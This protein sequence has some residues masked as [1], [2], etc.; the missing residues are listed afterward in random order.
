MKSNIQISRGSPRACLMYLDDSLSLEFPQPS[1]MSVYAKNGLFA[2]ETIDMAPPSNS[3]IK[4]VH[5]PRKGSLLLMQSLEDQRPTTSTF[6]IAHMHIHPPLLCCFCKSEGSQVA[7][8][9]PKKCPYQHGKTGCRLLSS[10]AVM[11]AC[12]SVQIHN[13]CASRCHRLLQAL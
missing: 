8:Y 12:Q 9:K 1:M 10:H 2:S 6:R 13:S 3:P 4:K 11:I 7:S 5:V